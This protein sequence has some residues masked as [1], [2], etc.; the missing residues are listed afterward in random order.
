LASI[1][2]AAGAC[3]DF[4][5]AGTV[6]VGL[7]HLDEELSAHLDAY[8]IS[9]KNTFFLLGAAAETNDSA[10]EV[11]FALTGADGGRTE[12]TLGLPSGWTFEAGHE[13][14][15]LI[16][17]MEQS[18]KVRRVRAVAEDLELQSLC[19]YTVPEPRLGEKLPFYVARHAGK[20][21]APSELF[22]QI[23]QVQVREHCID[24]DCHSASE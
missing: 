14:S 20:R 11:D 2:A 18:P 3:A 5:P 7:A 8:N 21:P 19:Q 16:A 12:Q 24:P 10:S 17:V 6:A 9:D 23:G 22:H 1:E 13:G 15:S 4:A